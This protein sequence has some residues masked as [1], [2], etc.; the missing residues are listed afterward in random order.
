MYYADKRQQ[1]LVDQ[2]Y[3]FEV[4]QELPFMRDPKQRDELMLSGQKEQLELL[5]SILQND[6][7][8]LEKEE[9]NYEDLEEDDDQRRM[10]K[11]LRH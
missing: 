4:I 3:Y 10:E 11:D 2:G 1:F 6:E 7:A 9:E 5:A 8:K